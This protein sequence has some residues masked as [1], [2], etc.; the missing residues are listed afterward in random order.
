[1]S[2][3]IWPVVFCNRYSRDY[4]CKLRSTVYNI[5]RVKLHLVTLATH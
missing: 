5:V 1:M 4:I 3:N 2:V